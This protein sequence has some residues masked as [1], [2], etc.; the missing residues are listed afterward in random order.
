MKITD[1]RTFIAR[2]LGRNM[3]FV[4]VYTDDGIDGIGEAY[5]VGP[6]DATAATIDYFKE[7][8]VG[9]SPLNIEHLWAKMYNCARFPGGSVVN[10]AISGIEHA[11]W[12]IA[13]KHF[14]TP[15]YNLLGGKCRDKIRVYQ[16][17]GGVTP[18]ELAENALALIEKYGYTALKIGPHPPGG[19]RMPIN[20]L[21][22]ESAARL[23]AV[24]VAVGDDVDIG[25]DPH[26]KIFEP[27]K[28]LMMAQA[29]E[30]YRPFFFEEPLRPENIDALARLTSQ[31]NV[32]SA[33]NDVRSISTESVVDPGT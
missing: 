33:A 3:V 16:S 27:V 19:D 7:L 22:R 1:V 9:E 17:P 20:K 31:V 18:E 26:A 29:L 24:R 30:P 15:V 21:I 10:A 5:S 2:D 23:E 13:G 4:K 6:D 25:V 14:N 11:L 8:V 28:A 12:D 32:P